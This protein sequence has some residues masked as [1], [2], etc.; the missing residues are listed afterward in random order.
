M[1]A[2]GETVLEGEAGGVKYARQLFLVL[3][4][5]FLESRNPAMALVFS[6]GV[7]QRL[8]LESNGHKPAIKNAV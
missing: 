8:A 1:E 5:G 7:H 3:S 2:G 4:P 6:P